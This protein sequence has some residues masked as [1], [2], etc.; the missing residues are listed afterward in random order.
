MGGISIEKSVGRSRRRAEK[1]AWKRIALVKAITS[2][3]AG[4]QDREEFKHFIHHG[5]TEYTKM[6]GVTLMPLCN[7]RA[8]PVSYENSSSPRN[9]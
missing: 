8:L 7:L 5:D 6:H 9:P 1:G 2:R 4:S 3:V